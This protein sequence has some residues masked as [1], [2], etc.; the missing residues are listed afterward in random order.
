MRINME[1]KQDSLKT[2]MFSSK[3]VQRIHAHFEASE[4]EK[5]AIRRLG[6]E[7]EVIFSWPNLDEKA[8]KFMGPTNRMGAIT[9]L[10]DGVWGPQSTLIFATLI[11][12]K[13]AMSEIE[14]GFRRLKGLL[15]AADLPDTRSVEI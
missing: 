5:E 8:A 10:T 7:K 11:D 15:A 12:A 9:L 4:E 14:E 13:A 3:P 6:L 1:I 2:G